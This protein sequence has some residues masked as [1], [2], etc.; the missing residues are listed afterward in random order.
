[1]NNELAKIEGEQTERQPIAL[2]AAYGTL[3]VGQGNWRYILKDRSTLL[4]T[5]KTEPKFTMYGRNSGFPV[6]VDR[7]FNENTP[8]TTEIEYDLFAVYDKDVLES[9]DSLEGCHY[10]PN[11]V[12]NRFYDCT[13]IKTPHGEAKMY[14]M[15]QHRDNGNIIKNGNW[16]K[17]HED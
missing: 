2:I 4:G 17:R 11:D 13:F 12:R 5:Y 10:P 14:V 15:H 8:A 7:P 6:V 3:R 9:V 1:M 16:I